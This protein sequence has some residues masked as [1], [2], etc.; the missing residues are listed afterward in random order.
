MEHV[1]GNIN[2]ALYLGIQEWKHAC[3]PR[4]AHRL[5]EEEFRKCYGLGKPSL[6][7]Y[8]R[9]VWDDEKSLPQDD[10]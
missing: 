5:L 1:L 7:I 10:S 6:G 3:G 9:V 2:T 4:G 8:K